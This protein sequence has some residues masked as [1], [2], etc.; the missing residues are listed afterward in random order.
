MANLADNY[1]KIDAFCCENQLFRSNDKV[2]VALSGGA[3]SVFLLR[4]LIARDYKVVAAHCNFH[5]RDAESMRDEQFVRELCQSIDVPLQVKDFD[6]QAVARQEHISIEMAARN[7]RYEWF[8]TLRQ[9]LE[10]DSIAVAHHQ[11]DNIESILLN[12]VRGTGI[13]GLC[14]IQPRNGHIVRPLLCINRAEIRAGLEEMNQTFVDDS[15]NFDN[16]YSRNRIRLN[17]MPILRS[18]NAGADNNILTTIENLNEIRK[19]YEESI[20]HSIR[21]CCR[22]EG[23]TLYIDINDLNASTSPLSVLHTI[24]EPLGFNR[25]QTQQLLQCKQVGKQFLSATHTAIVDR[26]DILVSATKPILDLCNKNDNRHPFIKTSIVDAADCVIMHDRYHAYLDAEAVKGELTVRPTRPGDRFHPFGMKGQ[27]L[28][29]DL[30]TDLKVNRLERS[31]QMVMCD[32]E[33]ILWVIGRR[34]SEDCRVTEKTRR[35]ICLD[36][37]SLVSS[38]SAST[39]P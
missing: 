16:Q 12:L 25:T 26:T 7:L 23:D 22:Q 9:T 10:A 29:S 18:I 17:V 11:D 28:V 3:D 30:L 14:G 15:T 4:Y 27:K 19:V 20:K 32:D 31:Q 33:R 1:R 5:L 36:A 39:E 8:E 6:T 13:K 34:V 35:V 37:S 24:M 38:A 2:L 21:Q